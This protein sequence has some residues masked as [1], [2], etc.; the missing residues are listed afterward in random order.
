[1]VDAAHG[2][3]PQDAA[4]AVSGI[5]VKA[6]LSKETTKMVRYDIIED[7]DRLAVGAV[8]VNKESL[9]TPYPK[10]IEIIIK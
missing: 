2:V 4:E 6:S 3:P 1:M 8:Y 10:E 5:R 9:P 7:A